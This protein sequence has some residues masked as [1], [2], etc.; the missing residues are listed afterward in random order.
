MM[1]RNV[2]PPSRKALSQVFSL[3]DEDKTGALSSSQ[4]VKM[5]KT[6]LTI[7]TSELLSDSEVL[8]RSQ[9]AANGLKIR[10]QNV[11][12]YDEF[13]DAFYGPYQRQHRPRHHSQHKHEHVDQGSSFEP[14]FDVI[15]N[16]FNERNYD[17]LNEVFPFTPSYE[18]KVLYDWQSVPP[19]CET[20]VDL[21]NHGDEE[22]HQH[23]HRRGVS[24]VSHPLDCYGSK[25][26][27][28]STTCQYSLSIRQPSLPDL[29]RIRVNKD[30]TI[31]DMIMMI[32]NS[33]P[34]HYCPPPPHEDVEVIWCR[35]LVDEDQVETI[36]L[37]R[38]ATVQE[39]DFFFI[40]RSCEIQVSNDSEYTIQQRKNDMK[41]ESTDKESEKSEQNQEH[42][43]KEGQSVNSNDN[44]SKEQRKHHDVNPP[45]A[46]TSAQLLLS[47]ISDEISEV[48]V[49]LQQECR[50]LQHN[51]D[52]WQDKLIILRDEVPP[53][54]TSWSDGSV[55]SSADQEDMKVQLS[56]MKSDIKMLK[57]CIDS[58]TSST[59]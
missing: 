33:W 3:F 21:S 52:I 58:L 2:A 31:R 9:E 22:H 40:H 57:T 50:R 4:F 32:V 13:V 37:P 35:T 6:I 34:P 18:Y 27:R 19:N 23:H 20:V 26:A 36:I 42:C 12:A 49:H 16:F 48:R 45:A 39:V 46:P 59:K 43:K 38:D 51:L 14:Y 5:M 25:K 28:I 47:R 7:K 56:S 24:K 29:V 54:D 11:I 44:Q 30:H 15:T 53:G 55:L 8:L 10:R 17:I 41:E 1:R